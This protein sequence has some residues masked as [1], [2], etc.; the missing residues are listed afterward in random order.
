MEKAKYSDK[1]YL[2][3]KLEEVAMKREFY[4]LKIKLLEAKL[5][6]LEQEEAC[7]AS[8]PSQEVKGIQIPE[9][10]V[11]GKRPVE[12]ETCKVSKE[13]HSSREITPSYK[14]SLEKTPKK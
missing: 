9:N 11:A 10:K 13:P 14:E 3:Q 4:T 12:E 5:R 1:D 8:K 7:Q 2:V 6:K